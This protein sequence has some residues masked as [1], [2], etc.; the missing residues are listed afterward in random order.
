MF[1]PSRSCRRAAPRPRRRDRSGLRPSGVIGSSIPCTAPK[2]SITFSGSA[3]MPRGH[4]EQRRDRPGLQQVEGVVSPG[5]LDVLRA[6]RTGRR[7]VRRAPPT[8]RS[9]HPAAPARLVRSSATVTV[10]PPGRLRTLSALAPSV[11]LDDL[12]GGHVNHVMVRLDLAGHQRLAQPHRGVD[13]RLRAQPGE[14]VGREQHAGGLAL[15][16]LLHHDRQRDV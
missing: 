1:P 8:P 3:G 16:H 9:A 12:A 5:P 14:R 15:D 11:R 2:E 7:P 10:P 13:D 6:H 4:G